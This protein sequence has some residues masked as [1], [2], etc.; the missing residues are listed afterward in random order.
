MMVLSVQTMVSR[1]PAPPAHLRLSQRCH[2]FVLVDNYAFDVVVGMYI[3]SKGSD[4]VIM[5]KM[6]GH[7][8]VNLGYQG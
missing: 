8:L 1:N 2:W 3:V 5:P 7:S 6:S 4:A